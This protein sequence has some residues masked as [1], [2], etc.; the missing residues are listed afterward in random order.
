[1]KKIILGRSGQ[2]VLKAFHLLFIGSATDSMASMFI[3]KR[4][5][6]FLILF[7]HAILLNAQDIIYQE[8]KGDEQVFQYHYYLG[9][10]SEFQKIRCVRLES[11]DTLEDQTLFTDK[12]Y[13]NLSWEYKRTS[14]NTLVTANLKGNMVALRGIRDGEKISE[15]F[16][17]DGYKWIQVFPLNPG[18]EKWLSSEEE[19]IKFWVIG[20]A[21][22]ADMDMNKFY[23][24]KE[25][26]TKVRIKNKR[27]NCRRVNITLSGWRSV[28]WDGDFFFRKSDG[29]II[30]Y[31]GGGPP[32]EPGS[33]TTL[34]KENSIP[35]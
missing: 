17:L 20:T 19:D 3:Y 9:E 23:A 2:K 35:D 24:E 32:G 21:S 5:F 1:M 13:K 6:F 4:I 11:N 15:D 7:I 28:F 25:E 33:V 8:K 34:I 31:N 22:S 12:D 18:L 26:T 16:E 27:Y 14:D 30:K 29:R 10:D